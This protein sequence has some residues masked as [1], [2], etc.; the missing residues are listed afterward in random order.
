M[1]GFAGLLTNLA[2]PEDALRAAVTRMRDTLVHRGPDDAGTH[3]DPTAGY[4]VGF[5]RLAIMDLSPAGHQPMWS[6]SGRFVLAF[7]GEVFNHGALRETLRSMGSTFRGHS[8]TEVILAAFEAWG[9]EAAVPRFIGM[10][11]MAVWDTRERT[12]TLIRDRLGIKPLYVYHEAGYLAFG[13]ELKALLAGPRFDRRI[14]LGAAAE[15]LRSLYVPGT[16]SIWE[17]ARKVPP[18]HTLT[19]RDASGPM[20]EAKPYWSL[21]EAVHAG[22]ANPFDGDDAAVVDA[23]DALLR[24]AVRLRME[25]DVPLGALLSGGIDS[26]LVVALLQEQSPRPIRT[27]SVGFDVAAHDEAEHADAVAR[28]LGTDHT[29]V[30]MRGDDALAYVPRLPDLYDE[31]HADASQLAAFL[32]C[33]VARRSVTVALS[34]DGGD[35]VWGGYNRYR[36]RGGMSGRALGLP[37]PVRR[38]AGA[39]LG[40]LSPAAWD[41]VYAAASRALPVLRG[42]RLA[43]DKLHKLRGMLLAPDPAAAYGTLVDVWPHPERVVRGVPTLRGAVE[44]RVAAAWP[45]RLEDRLLLADQQLYLPDDQL[46]KTDRASMGASLE[47]RVPL[48]DHRIVEWSWRLPWRTKV[49]DGVSKWVLR[50]VAYR[51]IPR[52]LLE[53]PKMGFTLPLADWLRG[54]LRPWAEELLSPGA[55]AKDG[56][57]DP[58]PIRRDWA[59]VIAGRDVRAL[60]TW[61]VLMLQAWRE[62]WA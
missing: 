3:V 14:D 1:C 34:G 43:G 5:R 45:P 26:S 12:L 33:Q 47:L 53:R 11:A 59:A 30:R 15:F 13:S 41:A 7:N 38:A 32:V 2:M 50:Q 10:F 46:V 6:A 40:V 20:P 9:I 21:A 55:L 24:D 35:E 54:P 25:A 31:P 60:R 44:S 58:A 56:L 42:E 61:S 18:G 57:L 19:V 8:D 39:G 4:A 49:R 52:D 36:F 22:L 23:T 27:F 29:L 51:R 48:L 16:A 17:R 28:H 62:R 37:R